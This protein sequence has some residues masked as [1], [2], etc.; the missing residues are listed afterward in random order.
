MSEEI[1]VITLFGVILDYKTQRPKDCIDASKIIDRLYLGSYDNAATCKEGLIKYEI[2]H[3]LT[4]GFEMPNEFP[5]DFKYHLVKLQDSASADIAS[6]FDE[7]FKFIDD[8]L[9]DQKNRVL[10]HCFAG[11]SRS[12]TIVIG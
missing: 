8:A 7:C 1:D 10:V 4:I 3:I 2:T 12:A 6:H 11:I 9:A 5:Q